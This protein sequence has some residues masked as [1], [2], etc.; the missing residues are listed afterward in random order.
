MEIMARLFVLLLLCLPLFSTAGCRRTYVASG[1]MEPLIPMNA[2][3]SFEPLGDR[4]L[5]RGDVIAIDE[6]ED[7][8][9]IR[10][11]RVIAL[12]GDRVRIE[13]KRVI[14]NGRPLQ[15]PYAVF[16]DPAILRPGDPV[17]FA[18]H[19]DFMQEITVG[20]SEVF[21][22]CDNRDEAAEDSRF[23][24]PFVEGRV[25]GLIVQGR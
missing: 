24:G 3:V 2:V 13:A 15:E 8:D 21:V 4:P 5:A 12:P 25:R 1:C 9:N 14:L 20:L 17:T 22:L 19:R 10:M 11:G 18:T 7:F 23:F 6:V 16:R